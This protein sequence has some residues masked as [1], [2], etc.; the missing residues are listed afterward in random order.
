MRVFVLNRTPS[1]STVVTQP[2]EF[3]NE[4]ALNNALRTLVPSLLF[5]PVVILLI[6]RIVR[7]QLAPVNRL[8]N[9][10]D[11]QNAE[12]VNALPEQEVPQ[13]VLPFIRAINR[14]LVRVAQLLDQQRRFIAD[15][16]HEL[17]SPLTALS[18]QVHNL[19]Q[20]DSLV[21]VRELVRLKA[22][23]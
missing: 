12:R 11:Q 3:R 17:R 20:A 16:A 19:K 18:L 10:L 14:L 7:I 5:L 2:T 13:E 9:Y 6:I 8:A 22:G 21:L 1:E 23:L 15:A 4:I